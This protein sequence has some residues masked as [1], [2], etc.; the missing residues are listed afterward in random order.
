MLTLEEL[1]QQL[2][3]RSGSDLH[4]S[5]GSP[6]K[7]RI[8]GKLVNVDTEILDEEQ[9]QKLVYSVLDNDQIARFERDLELDMSFGISGLGR[10]R[11]NVFMQR[12]SVATAMRRIPWEI[13][14]LD[15]LRASHSPGNG[16]LRQTKRAGP[17]YR[18]D[19]EWKEHHTRQYDRLH[20]L[21]QK[22]AYSD[23]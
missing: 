20:K 2:V 15:D 21:W 9:S 3:E 14:K 16:D 4:I 22:R 1:L 17:R 7:L 23:N 13:W 8:D 12:G 19:G 10:F 6:P 18:G 11:T 5:A